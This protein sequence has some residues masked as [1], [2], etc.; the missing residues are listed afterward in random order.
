MRIRHTIS[1]LEDIVS[2]FSGIILSIL[3]YDD[4]PFSRDI[5]RDVCSFD[6]QAFEVVPQH[7][8]AVVPSRSCGPCMFHCGI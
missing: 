6:T 7:L 1:R 4:A 8:P 2:K 5:V 3:L